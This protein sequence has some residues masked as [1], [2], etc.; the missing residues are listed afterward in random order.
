MERPWIQFPLPQTSFKGEIRCFLYLNDRVKSRFC[1]QMIIC[2]ETGPQF[3]RFVQVAAVK[4]M[5]V[6]LFNGLPSRFFFGAF[7]SWIGC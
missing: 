7:W 4:F 3:V 2:F 1:V 5:A 6:P